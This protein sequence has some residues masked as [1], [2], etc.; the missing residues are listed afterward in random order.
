MSHKFS[1]NKQ[2]KSK[3]DLEESWLDDQVTRKGRVDHRNIQHAPD[4][5]SRDLEP[6]LCNA[7][8]TQIFPKQARVR[9]LNGRELLCN[10]RTAALI[11]RSESVR[12][13]SPLTVGDLVKVEGDVVVGRGARKN[14]VAR[15]APDREGLVHVLAANID[16]VVIVAAAKDPDFS[17][18]LVDRFLIVAQKQNIP[19]VLCVNKM[20]LITSADSELTENPPWDLYRIL[21]T[22][23]EVSALTHDH[24]EDLRKAIQ[25]KRV[26]FC[27]HSGVGKTSLLNTLLKRT[28]GAVGDVNT[29]TGK[30]KHTTSSAIV[31]VHENL[32][33]F[34]TPGVREFGLLEINP[35][36]LLSY[37]PELE[38]LR[39][40]CLD[41]CEHIECDLSAGRRFE[42]YS[43]IYASLTEDS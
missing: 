28:A 23:L 43:R 30:G 25:D 29:V 24:T 8:V 40:K 1:K 21:C 12:E 3:K 7:Y 39:K 32:V 35:D 31:H 19:V 6:A 33:I 42:S 20:D 17:P 10:L 38:E 4:A 11:S 2:T 22:V 13:R 9:F 41:S 36:D 26:L 14:Q 15:P 18:G 5:R 37:C 34:D 27:G 16:V